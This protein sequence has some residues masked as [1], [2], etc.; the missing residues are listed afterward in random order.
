[1]CSRNLFLCPTTTPTPCTALCLDS[2]DQNDLKILGSV[3]VPD[4]YLESDYVIDGRAL[5]VPIKG[6][7]VF[8][9]NLSE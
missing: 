9:A 3:D 6:S 8:S 2:F 1:M 5:L 4:L 7:G